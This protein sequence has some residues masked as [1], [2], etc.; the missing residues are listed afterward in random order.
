M[1]ESLSEKKADRKRREARLKRSQFEADMA[2]MA[3][4]GFSFPE[5]FAAK[6]VQLLIPPAERSVSV[7]FPQT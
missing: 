6:G 2:V 3:D 5:Y 1:A 4:R 7:G